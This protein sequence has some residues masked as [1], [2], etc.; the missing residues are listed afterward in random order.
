MPNR[1]NLF[2]D[3]II[4]YIKQWAKQKN[5]KIDIAKEKIVGYRFLNNPRTIDILLHYNSRFLGIEAKLQETSGTAYQKLVYTL[6]DCKKA[7]IPVIIVFSGAGIKNDV[8]SMLV[9]SGYGIEVKFTEDGKIKED[10]PILLQRVAIELG[11]NWF[12][13]L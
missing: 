10:K 3:A 9:T 8:K 2:R 13:L 5:Y 7:P 4:E 1:G 11:I 6:E 12:D